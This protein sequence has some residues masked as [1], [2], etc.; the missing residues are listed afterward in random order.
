MTVSENG[1]E[2][3]PRMMVAITK[4]E[5]GKRLEKLLD[6]SNVPIW[7]QCRGNGTAP[8]ELMDVFGF[9]GTTRLLTI[10]ILPKHQITALFDLMSKR[11]NF[12]QRGGGVAISIPVTGLQSHVITLLKDKVRAEVEKKMEERSNMDMAETWKKQEYIVI[13]VSVTSGYSDDVIDAA[14]AVGAR[15][16]TVI[17]GRRRNSDRVRQHFGVATQEEQDFVMIVAKKDKK[18]AI[19]GAICDQCG[20]STKARGVVL[21]LPVDDALGLEE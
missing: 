2:L 15:G 10:S 18:S 14:R 16:G 7:Y 20:M 4:V 1:R 6:E 21:S 9:S 17:K 8:S 3:F 19:M 12:R 11:L 5:D 13:W